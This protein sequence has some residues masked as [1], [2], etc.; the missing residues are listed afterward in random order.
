MT[1]KVEITEQE[2]AAYEAAKAARDR[3]LAALKACITS[4]PDCD[5][6]KHRE[7]I[8]QINGVARDAIALNEKRL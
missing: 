1:R 3:L 7:R 5:I 6:T 8:A 2:E 4:I